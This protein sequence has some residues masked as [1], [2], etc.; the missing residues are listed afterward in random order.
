MINKK[1]FLLAVMFISFGIFAQKKEVKNAEKA[2]EKENFDKAKSEIQL[3]EQQLDELNTRWKI[4]FY[5]AKGEALR[6]KND[7]LNTS[8]ED[9]INSG[10]AFENAKKLD[11]EDNDAIEGLQKTQAAMVEQA[12]Q[13]QNEGKHMLAS[14]KMIASYELNKNDTLYLYYAAGNA[15]T[16][17]EYDIS[18]DYYK[19]LQDLG[20]TGMAT[21]YFAVNKETKEKQRFETK[22]YRDL[23]VQSGDYINPTDEET[24][25]KKGE[26]AK[27]ISLIYI[28][29]GEKEKAIKAIERAK[30]SN[31]DDVQLMQAEAD[32]YYQLDNLAKYQEIMKEITKLRPEDPIL[33]LNLGITADQA[34]DVEGAIEYYKKAI[35]LDEDM[36]EPHLNIAAS[37]L[38]KE[39]PIV[40]QMNQLGMSAA[41]NKKYEELKEKRK[42]YYIEARPHLEKVIEIQPENV[43]AIRT[44]MN[45]HYQLGNDSEA[46][47]L[48]VQLKKL[49]E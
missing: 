23:S 14:E 44:M 27:N 33:F 39:E 47:K 24:Q 37:I 43:D 4:R 6:G 30:E 21:T 11:E 20:F 3:A 36:I 26:I 17:K 41:D 1:M 40:N 38:K 7:G 18:L 25:S 10:K 15:V 34:G 35:E 22:T 8:L 12:I 2:I 28:Q 49:T 19:E 13:N 31:P 48:R 16:A 29:K 5:I 46:E 32:L 42:Q 9:L 45:I